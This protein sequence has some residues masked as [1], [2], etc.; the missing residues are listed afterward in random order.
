MPC[1]SLGPAQSG[2][3]KQGTNGQVFLLL[4]PCPWYLHLSNV[5]LVQSIRYTIVGVFARDNEEGWEFRI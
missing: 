3:P 4:P 2:P 5:E 1:H